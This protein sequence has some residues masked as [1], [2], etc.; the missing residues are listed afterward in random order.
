MEICQLYY[1]GYQI[2]GCKDSFFSLSKRAK[3]S[4][5]YMRNTT[6]PRTIQ[7]IDRTITTP[8]SHMSWH[9]ILHA[10]TKLVHTTHSQATS[11]CCLTCCLISQ[12]KFSKFFFLDINDFKISA[13]YDADRVTC[14]TTSKSLTNFDIF[15]GP[16]LIFW[17]IKNKL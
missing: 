1:E 6:R 7:K 12:G 16:F 15:L 8:Q 17:K 4:Q 2:T 11:Q 5:R 3:D 10:T 13:F 14:P 9:N